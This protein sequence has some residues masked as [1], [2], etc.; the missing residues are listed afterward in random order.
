V[1]VARPLVSISIA[2]YNQRALIEETLTSALQQ[3]YADLEVVVADDGSTDGTAEIILEYASRYPNRL[4]PL[5]GGP[6]IGITKNSNRALRACKGTYIAFQGGDDI[7]LPGKIEKQ[8]RWFEADARRVLCGHDVEVFDGRSGRTMCLYSR[9]YPLVNGNGARPFVRRGCIFA[10][11]SV[12]VR[13]SALPKTLF[14]ER[15]TVVSDWKLWIDILASG[16][17]FGFVEGVYGR[18]RRHASNTSKIARSALLNDLLMT[19][20]MV[21]AS[22]PHLIS[23]CRAFRARQ[24]LSHALHLLR[25]DDVKAARFY[26]SNALREGMWRAWFSPALVLLLLFPSAITPIWEIG[27]RFATFESRDA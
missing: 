13:A 27:K 24:F 10:S 3:E 4:V 9:D 21:E 25:T 5:V 15:L 11:T 12:M 7:F 22:Y 18:Y 23:D 16:G 26:M 8:V 2:A 1:T 14:D 17:E 6:N 19:L 20:G